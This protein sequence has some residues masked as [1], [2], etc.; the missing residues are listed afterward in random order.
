VEPGSTLE[1]AHAI[2]HQLEQQIKSEVQ[3]SFVHVH[4]E[5]DA[6]QPEQ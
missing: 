5:P 3:R 6:H 1:H 4:V 2:S